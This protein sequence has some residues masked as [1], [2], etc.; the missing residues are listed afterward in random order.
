[1][2]NL[3]TLLRNTFLLNTK[4]NFEKA[5]Q[6]GEY[7]FD[8][9]TAHASDAFFATML[10]FFGPLWIIYK[11]AMTAW[12][13]AGGL[14]QGGTQKISD[15]LMDLRSDLIDRWDSLIKAALI[16]DPDTYKGLFPNGH[17]PFQTGAQDKRLNAVGAL[18]EAIGTNA[19]LATIKAEIETWYNAAIA[20]YGTKQ[21]KKSV[22]KTSSAAVEQARVELCHAM[23]KDLMDCNSHF[24]K[25]PELS[26]PYFNWE[27]LRPGEQTSFS[28]SVEP[29]Q[30]K[31]LAKR[32]LGPNEQLK[33]TNATEIAAEI[34]CTDK[35]GAIPQKISIP[36]HSEDSY[37]PAQIG[38]TKDTPLI[39]VTNAKEAGTA[40]LLIEIVKG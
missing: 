36:P 26:A 8:A 32:T 22:T 1:M 3:P 4:K 28:I 14:Q 33:V 25:N 21:G 16:A 20:A 15:M 37:S 39:I 7:H 12:I 40:H 24:Y 34:G 30:S 9:L 11:N 5:Y 18:I 6:T 31:L 38:N 2:D 10:A 23:W 19:L 29:G 35:G 13:A 17:K 27:A